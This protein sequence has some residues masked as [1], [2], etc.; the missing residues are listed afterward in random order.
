MTQQSAQI[1]IAAPKRLVVVPV[2]FQ[3]QS[4]QGDPENVR[5]LVGEVER[6]INGN[7][8]RW[9]PIEGDIIIVNQ[10]ENHGIEIIEHESVGTAAR[11]VMDVT[12][13][14]ADAQ[15]LA[16]CQEPLRL[17]TEHG[18]DDLSVEVLFYAAAVTP[19]NLLPGFGDAY[20]GLKFRTT[21]L[22]DPKTFRERINIGASPE[23]AA[24][25]ARLA[26]VTGR[27]LD[28]IAGC[29]RECGGIDPQEALP[30]LVQ[31]KLGDDFTGDE[32]RPAW[33]LVNPSPPIAPPWAR[34]TS[35]AAP[36]L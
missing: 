12:T 28:C 29:Y 22:V 32:F 9:S 11:W 20:G 13:G 33:G 18:G 24:F 23:R 4:L 7:R 2:I 6:Q 1:R 31:A 17:A 10:E 27:V 3:R 30:R 21:E 19:E 8:H 25:H 26:A 36:A 5:L 15:F 35:S 14:I 16:A 34:R